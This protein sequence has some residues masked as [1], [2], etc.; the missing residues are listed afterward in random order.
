MLRAVLFL[1]TACACG[2]IAGTAFAQAAPAGKRE[3]DSFGQMFGR[4]TIGFDVRA[5]YE[6]VEEAR[7]PEEA[8]AFT[9]RTRVGFTSAEW[10]GLSFSVEGA[11]VREIDD[12]FNSTANGK[13]RY[14]VILDPEG[15][16]FNQA[17]LR[18]A[19]DKRVAATIGRQ[20]IQFDNQRFFGSASFRQHEQTF[21]AAQIAVNP[22]DDWAVRYVY[23]DKVNRVPGKG[24]PVRT[25][26]EQELDAHLLNVAWKSSVGTLTGYGYFVDNQDLPVQSAKTLGLRFVGKHPLTDKNRFEYTA[27]WAGQNP[28][29]NGA[30]ALDNDYVLLEAAFVTPKYSVR[31][32]HEMLGGNGAAG[33]QTPFATLFAFNGWA[34]RFLTTPANGL[35]DTYLGA[36]AKIGGGDFIVR[37]HDFRSDRAGISYGDEID[38]RYSRNLG[39]QFA[40]NVQYANFDSDTPTIRDAEKIWLT[41]EWKYQHVLGD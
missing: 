3:A 13:T 22:N 26:R 27:E 32:G 23:L 17:W 1:A 10:N 4:G 37:Y 21:D 11:D 5:R 24:H 39:K 25:A 9:V 7:L 34:D 2:G 40:A 15:S 6:N 35:R 12:D 18:Y 30:R 33:F 8:Q 29:A 41:L 36:T 19:P 16:E 31:L 14:P 20:R 28:Y 38:L